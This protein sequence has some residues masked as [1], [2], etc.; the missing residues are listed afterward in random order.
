MSRSELVAVIDCGTNTFNLLIAEVTGNTWKPIRRTKRVV[1]LGSQG[2]S[3]GLLGAAPRQRALNA[4]SSYRK[5]LDEYNVKNISVLGTAALRDARNGHEFLIQVKK[6]TGFDITL[7]SGKEEARLIY[8][9][10]KASGVLDKNCA[11]IMDIGGGSTEF[12]L[13]NKSKVFWKHSFRLGAA[14]LL[15]SINPSDPLLKADSKRL[16][17]ILRKELSPLFKVCEKHKPTVLVGSSGSFDTFI[18]LIQRAAPPGPAKAAKSVTTGKKHQGISLDE[19]KKLF[20]NLIVSSQAERLKMPGMLAMRADMLVMAACLVE[21]VR[22]T[23]RIKS[24]QQCSYA[25][26][27]GV[28]ST[29][30]DNIK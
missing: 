2:L 13:C 10:V 5:I 11:L 27:E 3:H 1:K 12:I 22:K 24:V 7:I 15:E 6:E 19:W 17:E 28:M 4:L 23:T 9:G 14:R 20:G 18:A 29:L 16:N 26:K 8:E 25:L 30:V 21:F